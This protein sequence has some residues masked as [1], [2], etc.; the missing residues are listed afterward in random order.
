MS[1]H[2][3]YVTKVAKINAAQAEA[4]ATADNQFVTRGRGNAK[5]KRS[6]YIGTTMEIPAINW[7]KL[8]PN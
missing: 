2:K 8:N 6:R 4:I 1:N 5:T 7:R 3:T